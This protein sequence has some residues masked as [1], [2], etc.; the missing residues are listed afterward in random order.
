MTDSDI[1]LARES[2]TARP[3]YRILTKMDPIRFVWLGSVAALLVACG[4]SNDA[5]PSNSGGNG[6]TGASSGSG[7]SGASSGNGGTGASGGSGG[8]VSS[9]EPFGYY[10]APTSTF[11]LPAT[12]GKNL[13]YDD[14]QASFPEVDWQTLSRLYIPA[15]M[16]PQMRLGNLPSRDPAS[17]L[18]ITNQGGQVRIG[19]PGAGSNYLFTVDGGKNWVITG[20][21]DPDSGTGDEAFP[22]HRCGEYSGSRGKYGFLSD[23]AF[24]KGTYLHMGIAVTDASDFELEYLE[25]TRS[26]FAGIRLL[27]QH[28]DGVPDLTMDNVR[29]HDNYVHDTDGEGTYFGW[30][31]GPPSA[32]LPHLVIYNN[33]F[34][35]T[36]NEA[37]QIQDLGDGTEVKNN[38]IA[39]AAMHWRDN[40]LGQYQDNNSQISSREGTI[41]I[42]DNVF[43][44]GAGSLLSFW[45]Q[46]QT[47]D[48]DRHV[49]FD[50]NYFASTKNLGGYVGGTSDASSSFDFSNNFLRDI[51]FSYDE[52]DPAAQPPEAIFSLSPN[53]AAVTFTS[54]TWEGSIPL[55]KYNNFTESGNQ[56]I[57]IAP[58]DFV[59]SGYPSATPFNSL[60]QWVAQSTLAPGSP[61]RVY[62]AGDL[63]M[64]DAEMY[65]CTAQNTGQ[66]PPEHPESWKKLPL[67]ADDFRVMEGSPYAGIGIQ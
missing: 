29:I 27:N 40:G 22:G 31:G 5:N 63:V 49:T 3:G 6:G 15:G 35:R 2:M 1:P 30:T 61:D 58:I 34:V 53:I 48:G 42:H 39:F 60:E 55:V 12:D 37:L 45:S 41:S 54:N 25:I 13:Y 8:T 24:I 33:R 17:P 28:Q 38:V 66:P 10:G 46:P 43:I 65:E 51:G 52:L 57:S 23:D 50:H 20:R 44:G 9:C 7:G 26:G 16:Y 64:Y 36:G 19:P 14:I 4:G 11:T 62:A 47:G 32:L 67:P 59:D 56:N 18:V 21:Y